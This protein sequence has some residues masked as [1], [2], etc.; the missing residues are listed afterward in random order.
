MWLFAWIGIR[1]GAAAGIRSG[2][3]VGL[4]A[5]LGGSLLTSFLPDMASFAA[6]AFLLLAAPLPIAFYLFFFNSS[7]AGPEHESLYHQRFTIALAAWL[8]A[9]FLGVVTFMVPVVVV[10]AVL[11]KGV[12]FSNS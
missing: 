11:G 8:P 10:P 12:S 1:L 6:N 3:I 2:A 4:I 7:P 9:F 5:G